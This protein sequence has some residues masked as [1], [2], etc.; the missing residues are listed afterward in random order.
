MAE[1]DWHS[2]PITRATPV[3]A[4]YRSTQN[5]RRFLAAE[6]GEE[7]RL[8]R[9]FMAWI[10]DGSAKNMGDVADAWLRRRNTRT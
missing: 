1:F 10:R 4:G 2:E 5:V 7:V 3:T 9:A 8:D 6:C